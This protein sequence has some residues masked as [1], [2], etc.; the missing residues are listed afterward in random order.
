MIFWKYRDILYISH[1]IDIFDILEISL[2]KA[3]LMD[4][5]NI[6]TNLEMD[7]SVFTSSMADFMKVHKSSKA[8]K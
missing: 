6:R 5:M 3:T 4:L 7:R 1:N 2:K 8:Y